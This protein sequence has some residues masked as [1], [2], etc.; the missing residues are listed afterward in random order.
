MIPLALITPLLCLNQV[1]VLN[2]GVYIY[3]Y[4][5]FMHVCVM[6][7]SVLRMKVLCVV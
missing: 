7:S 1:H 5:P 3:T 4:V 6:N 2:D